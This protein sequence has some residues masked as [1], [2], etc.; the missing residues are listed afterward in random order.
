MFEQYPNSAVVVQHCDAALTAFPSLR[1]K[2]DRDSDGTVV[3]VIAGTVP[4]LFRGAVYNIPLAM[5]LP[6]SYPSHPPSVLVTPTANMLVR[7]GR[8][9]DANGRV[10]HSMLAQWHAM[11]AEDR[12]L[13]ALISVLQNVFAMDP[14]VYA[15]PSGPVPGSSN[16]APAIPSKQLAS[17]NTQP[18][19]I[20]QNPLINQN[21]NSSSRTSL[22]FSN[23]LKD[24]NRATPPPV[25]APPPQVSKSAQNLTSVTMAPGYQSGPSVTPPPIPI[26]PA[27]ASNAFGSQSSINGG[28]DLQHP[29]PMYGNNGSPRFFNGSPSQ[30]PN[31]QKYQ[32]FGQHGQQQ[33]QH[34]QQQQYPRP[35]AQMQYQSPQHQNSDPYYQQQIAIPPSHSTPPPSQSMPVPQ[36]P[37]GYS[38]ATQQ[39]NHHQQHQF[40]QQQQQFYSNSAAGSP[41]SQ[42]IFPISPPQHLITPVQSS[43][44]PAGSPS[45]PSAIQQQQQKDQQAVAERE[46]RIQELRT[47]V[48]SKVSHAARDLEANLLRDFDRMRSGV[49]IAVQEGETRVQNVIM[50]L[51]Q[52]EAKV[53]RNSEILAAKV[54]EMESMMDKIAKEPEVDVDSV[55]TSGTSV[56]NQ[57][58]DVIAEEHALDDTLYYLAKALNAEAIE[59]SAF[60]KHTRIVARELFMKRALLKKIQLHIQLNS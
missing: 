30:S 8:N 43:F 3:L 14:P 7:A 10:Y 54:V 20:P 23:N 25:P 35:N 6:L 57:L 24:S 21:S 15:K 58:L 27:G 53:K 36:Y 59:L 31:F 39:S 26:K 12:S 28:A 60:M 11:K 48:A 55:L 46:R 44:S 52:E 56:H 33:L 18:P 38:Y 19:P 45:K 50:R 4:V 51:N 37:Q 5:F 32:Q 47:A 40:Q 34:Q 42:P 16:A 2:T 9:V 22:Q 29:A 49:G 1:P 13:V 17:S 41:Q